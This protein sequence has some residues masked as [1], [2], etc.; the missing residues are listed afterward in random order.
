MARMPSPVAPRVHVAVDRTRKKVGVA[1]V[2][3]WAA[4]SAGSPSRTSTMRPLRMRISPRPGTSRPRTGRALQWR[5]PPLPSPGRSPMAP[6][7]PTSTMVTPQAV[8]IIDLLA[9]AE[10]VVYHVFAYLQTAAIPRQSYYPAQTLTVHHLSALDQPRHLA[11]FQ[12]GLPWSPQNTH[13]PRAQANAYR[14]LKG[15]ED[16]GP[17]K[18]Y[19][20]EAEKN[21]STRVPTSARTLG[22]E[23][24]PCK[25]TGCE[26]GGDYQP[27]NRIIAPSRRVE[28]VLA[29]VKS[30]I[31][32]IL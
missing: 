30:E 21:R 7:S 28:G 3:A 14:K 4:G 29:V 9:E 19:Q 31:P 16:G 8:A 5:G 11:P 18:T 24:V 23:L 6:F 10:I 22:G 32:Q 13:P 15:V 26:Q 12:L 25:E 1:D 20:E 2:D 27:K 17:V